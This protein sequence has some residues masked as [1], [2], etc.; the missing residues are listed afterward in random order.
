MEETALDA[1]SVLLSDSHLQA[2]PLPG[3]GRGRA[4]G[5]GGTGEGAA[6][7]GRSELPSPSLLRTVFIDFPA[8]LAISVTSAQEFA[9]PII[10][11]ANL[12]G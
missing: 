12:S 3:A 11:Q 7:R 4:P 9:P 10:L 1:I 5:P 8:R 6:A 2:L